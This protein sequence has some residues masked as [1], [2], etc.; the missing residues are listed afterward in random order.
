MF[1]HN[2][3]YELLSGL[4]SKDLTFWLI[5]FPI[6][7]GSF[8]K[9][10]FS[11]VYEKDT[12]FSKID[13]AIVMNEDDVTLKSVIDSIEASDQPLMDVTYANKEEAERLLKE[14]DVKGIIYSGD[15]L[16]L[17]V[18]D[19]GIEQTI[20]STFVE[21]YNNRARI[22]KKTAET[23]HS[24][25]EK[26]AAVLSEDVKAANEV[27]LTDG[28]TDN[29][30]FYF[31][32]LIAMVALYGSLNGLNIAKNNQA[33]VSVLGARK[34][35][36]PTSKSL[37]TLASFCCCIIMQTMCMLICVT[38]LRFVL[39]VDFGNR[40]HLVYLAAIL[41]GIVGV[42]MG[43]FIGSVGNISSNTRTTISFSLSM[44]FCFLS[45]LMISSL[46]PKIALMFPWFDKLNPAAVIADSFYSLNIYTD[47]DRYLEKIATMAIMSAVLIMLS[48]IFTRRKKYASL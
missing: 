7:L 3:K 26:V 35:C 12:A 46:K 22:I 5:L 30:I 24:A 47:Y 16:S 10:A 14:G 13:T 41:G 34:Q 39:R 17:T 18:T 31:Y 29:L 1:L 4:R 23:D 2:L 43:F 37:S 19:K 21:K 15:E 11:G 44:I 40:L 9:I 20:L 42:S 6:I 28:N 27:P 32:N 8:F 33:D 38:F 25:V 48:L 45:G 36:S